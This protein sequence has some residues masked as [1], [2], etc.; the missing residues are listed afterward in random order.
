MKNY[1]IESLLSGVLYCIGIL[2][3][4]AISGQFKSFGF[5]LLSSI[6]FGLLYPLV[7]GLFHKIT[8]KKKDK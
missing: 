7:M 1:V 2:V 5:Y 3:I 6:I 4:D 8:S